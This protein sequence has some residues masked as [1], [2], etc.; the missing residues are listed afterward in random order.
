MSQCESQIC[1]NESLR[2]RRNAATHFDYG[3][4]NTVEQHI[5]NAGKFSAAKN[6]LFWPTQ[7]LKSLTFKY[8]KIMIGKFCQ[9]MW[10]CNISGGVAFNVW[11][12][13]N[14]MCAKTK[15][16]YSKPRTSNSKRDCKHD[17]IIVPRCHWL[18]R[19]ITS[20]ITSQLCAGATGVAEILFEQPVR[21]LR[22]YRG[23]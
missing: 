14:G 15:N 10:C 3:S 21:L 22:D 18:I 23:K 11:F 7:N 13:T 1:V 16:I 8:S 9:A 4:R 19:A 12:T 2:K 5:Y 20:S 6:K 17:R